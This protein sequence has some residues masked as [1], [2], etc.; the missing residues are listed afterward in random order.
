M[1]TF[2]LALLLT[3]PAH[4]Q[5]RGLKLA[6]RVDKPM[7]HWSCAKGEVPIDPYDTDIAPHCAAQGMPSP[8][9]FHYDSNNEEGVAFN[10]S[11]T[12]GKDGTASIEW[13]SFFVREPGCHI[14]GDEKS[15]IEIVEENKAHMVIKGRH[16]Q[17]ILFS[18]VGVVKR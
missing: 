16:G 3:F 15:H 17:V 14:K 1:R 4:A 8:Y 6:I 10:K 11:I 2:L 12:I 5:D 13:E 18:C 9:K 7:P